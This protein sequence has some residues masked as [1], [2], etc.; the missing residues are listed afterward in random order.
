MPDQNSTGS[1]R[2]TSAPASV[3]VGSTS[4]AAGATT[5]ATKNA[6]PSHAASNAMLID[7]VG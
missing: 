6:A 7:A 4:N 2:P 1:T 5:A 3:R